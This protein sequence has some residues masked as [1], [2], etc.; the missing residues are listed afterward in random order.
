ME[1]QRMTMVTSHKQLLSIM[2]LYVGTLCI[3]SSPSL[4]IDPQVPIRMQHCMINFSPHLAAAR[5][6]N[7]A[8]GNK[9]FQVEGKTYVYINEKKT[10]TKART[11][12]KALGGDLASILSYEEYDKIKEILTNAT[13]CK[14]IWIG[15]ERTGVN[16]SIE[17]IVAKIFEFFSSYRFFSLIT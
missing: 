14:Y 7:D 8:S 16:V 17:L 6:L 11:A 9:V 4:E 2:V 10:W 12:C 15:A 5:R 3:F 13:E 1:K